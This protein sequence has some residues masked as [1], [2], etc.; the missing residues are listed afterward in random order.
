MPLCMVGGEDNGIS[1]NAVCEKLKF[2]P[3]VGKIHN[4]KKLYEFLQKSNVVAIFVVGLQ[5][6]IQEISVILGS[7][8]VIPRYSIELLGKM[9]RC[10][11]C[12]HAIGSCCMG[13]CSMAASN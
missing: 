4:L 1:R 9:G 6:N 7:R 12:N 5:E 11:A 8:E 3:P 13:V 10:P 2:P